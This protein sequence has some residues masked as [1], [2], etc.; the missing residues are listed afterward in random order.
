VHPIGR[1]ADALGQFCQIAPIFYRSCI[2]RRRNR[3]WA[4]TGGTVVFRRGPGAS[5]ANTEARIS[6][7]S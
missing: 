7:I 1:T 2:E 4:P 5:E 6:G 3:Q